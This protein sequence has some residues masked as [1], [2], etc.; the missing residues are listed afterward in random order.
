MNRFKMVLILAKSTEEAWK[1]AVAAIWKQGFTLK[2]EDM[3]LTK[4]I[5]GLHVKI[6]NPTLTIDKVPAEYPFHGHS[7]QDYVDQLM[8]SENRWAFEYTYGE[9]LWSWVSETGQ[10]INQIQA[11][12]DRLAK[13]PQTRRAICDLAMPFKDPFPEKIKDPP[14]LRLVGFLLREQKPL[15]NLPPVK[16]LYT[17]V[18]FRSHDIFGA[19]YANWIALANLMKYVA[20]EISKKRG[21]NILIGE[22][23]NYSISGHVYEGD[24]E[25]ARKI[26]EGLG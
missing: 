11:A 9:R 1:R 14:C 24:F 2:T 17:T 5:V 21:E 13:S 6:Q 23:H 16:R 15:P 20:E 26:A 10:K 18:L 7:L 19:A 12:I 3:G 22:L 25:V 8:T 4:E